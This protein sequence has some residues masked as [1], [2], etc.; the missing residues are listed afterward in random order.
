RKG[1]SYLSAVFMGLGLAS[2][3]SALPVLLGA[4]YL[5]YRDK[6]YRDS[7]NYL[8]IALAVY[9]STY[10]ADFSLGL[11]AIINHHIDMY[12]Y[13][14]WRHG[15]SLP[16]ALNGLLKLLTRV[17]LWRYAGEL[18]A[19]ITSVDGSFEILDQAF[20][21]A[22]KVLVVVGIGLGSFLWYLFIPSLLYTTYLALTRA[23]DQELSAVVALSWLS[24]INVLAGPLDWY[25]VNVLPFL[26]L[27][28]C[29]ALSRAFTY[30]FKYVA[31]FFSAIQ[32]VLFVATALGVI[33]YSATIIK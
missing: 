7:L 28:A 18:N 1:K 21:P 26:Y 22:S 30:K 16:I 31:F 29:I 33:P 14:S 25:Y 5:A 13:M 19:V 11:D 27:N 9:F 4:V 3:A 32:V 15:F 2:K 23:S 17:E 10:S 8:L 6:G 24:L 12:K 20:T